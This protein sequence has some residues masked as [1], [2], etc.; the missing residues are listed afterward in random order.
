MAYPEYLTAADSHNIGNTQTSW[1]DPTQWGQALGNAGKM[2]A[3]SILSGANSFYN[4]AVTVGNWMGASMSENDTQT[5]IS[6]IDSDLGSY[7]RD[8][9]TAADV[10][11]FILGSLI[12]G[13]G[14]TKLLNAGQVA[15]KTTK[16]YGLV[17]GNMG[18]AM[19]VLAPDTEKFVKLAATEINANTTALNLL[20]RNTAKALGAGFWQNTLE[21][22]AFETA[23]QVTMFRSPILEQQ[24]G[25]DIVT[26]IALGG[27]VGGTIFGAFTAAKLRGS[28]KSAVAAE[29]ALRMPFQQRTQFAAGTSDSEKIIQLAWDNQTAA[30]PVIIKGADGNI[31]N[32]YSVN[33]NL[34]DSKV[35]KNN[36]EIRTSIHN[37]SDGDKELGNIVANISQGADAQTVLGNFANALK[38]SRVTHVTK[39]EKELA[40]ALAAKEAGKITADEVPAIASRVVRLIG[41]DAGTVMD[42]APPILSLGD[43]YNGQKEIMGVVKTYGFST[44]NQWD[45]TALKGPKAHLEAEARYIWAANQTIKEGMEINLHDIPLLERA[46]ETG[47]FNIKIVTGEGPSLQVLTPNSA[48]E[49]WNILKDTKEQT[50]NLILEKMSLKGNIPI[51]QGTEAAAAI[52]N[53]KRGYLEGTPTTDTYGD[54]MASQDTTKKYL[55]SMRE[56]GIS[57]TQEEI[58]DTRFLPKYG[59]VVY[60]QTDDVPENVMDA[61]TFFKGQ[62]REYMNAARNVVSK[63]LGS[64]ADD[65][66]PISDSAL[67]MANRNGAGAG[68]FSFENSNYGTLGST[69]AVI[70][71]VTRRAIEASRKHINDYLAPTLTQL[72]RNPEAAIEFESINQKI[73][74]SGKQ[75]ILSEDGSALQSLEKNADILPD[76]IPIT[77]A[78]TLAAVKSHIALSGARTTAYKEMRAVQ[79]LQDQKIT[80]VFRPIRPDLKQYPFFFFVKDPQVTGSGHMSMVHAA[81]EKELAA[82]RARVPENYEVILK[83]D[84]EDFYKA[85]QEYEFNRSLHENYIDTDLKNNGVM[86]NFFP[87]SDSGRI[88]DDIIQQHYRESDV[89]NREL[90]RFNYEPQM[91]MLQDLGEEYSRLDV[92]RFAS[93]RDVVEQT[94]NNPYFNYI[95]TALDISKAN[96]M[97]LLYSFN[98]TLDKAVSKAVSSIR[99]VF[100]NTKS[101]GQLDQINAALDKFGMKPA[102]YDA[103]LQMLANHTAPRGELTKF[104]RG[105]NSLLSLFTLGLD[106]LNSLNNAIGSN[107][108]RMTELKHLTSAIAKGNNEVAG[109]L[110]GLARSRVPG[111][112]DSILSPSKLVASAIKNFWNDDGTLMNRYK[113]DGLIKDRLEQLKLLADDFTLKGTESVADLNTRL[114]TGFA[115]AKGMFDNFQKKGEKLTANQLAEEFNRFISADVMRQ[116]TE[117]GEKH[118][119]MD[120]RTAKAYINTFVNRVEGN[121]LAS[122]RPLIFQGPVGQAIGLFQSYQFN[123][124]QQLFRYSAEG[125]KKD[126]ATLLGLQ[127]TLYGLQS[128]PG[129]Q[130]INTHIVGQMSG[131]TEHRDAYD[132]VYGMVGRTA[133]DWL[134][135]GVPSNILQANIYSR[136]DINPR[137]ITVLPTNMQE[138]PIVQGWGKFLGNT[139]DTMKNIAQGGDIWQSLLQGLEHNGVSRPLAGFAQVLNGF[140]DGTV[141]SYSKNGSLLYSN[142]LMSWASF[143]RIAGGRPLDEAIINDQMFRVKSYEATRK[144]KLKDLG[145]ALRTNMV[146]GQVDITNQSMEKFVNRYTELGGKQANFNKYM[147]NLYKQANTNQSEILANSLSNPHSYKMQLL[148]GGTPED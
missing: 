41:E 119:L 28:I 43:L 93:K 111:T 108:L 19:R 67:L 65:L 4:T 69:M 61:I 126:L 137:Q 115:R 91:N 66:L 15:L 40:K 48:Y 114:D 122:Q 76:Y 110:A 3:S 88:V 145:E 100:A 58:K 7:Y 64:I 148:M 31:I 121:I 56:K 117:V 50:A 96:E 25:M 147:M 44:K 116:I 81:S 141:E 127:S 72:T 112:D 18:K 131:N 16:A 142:D 98:Q 128:L 133:G 78:D 140:T 54:L 80:N 57:M 120:G 38:I 87:K 2:A 105:A 55:E 37:L 77:T 113:G 6:G 22:A 136:G 47:Q 95:K 146:E 59:K 10:G 90:I 23:A 34:Y 123:L 20:N 101:T 143:T 79:G 82:L 27:A 85:R 68:L 83:G 29:D 92:S 107:I 8:N 109:E 52:V 138:I 11:G 104:V 84:S 125:T 21:A 5:W 42:G 89:L 39:P 30:V 26:N 71:S 49:L 13:L 33:K 62:Q 130:F 63:N 75:W 97:G 74:R 24:D 1:Y 12:P 86:S 134:L 53:T 124:L 129:F 36:N 106:P 139:K 99:D 73:S 70:G 135:Y 32:N 45:A 9:K 102:Y 51:E 94:A 17:G 144:E 103:S 46:W 118:G 35:A 14:A 132:Q 60:N